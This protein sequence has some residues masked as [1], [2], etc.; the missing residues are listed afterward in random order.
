[1]KEKKSEIGYKD[2]F[3]QKEYLKLVLAGLISRFGDS[4]DSLAFTWL[5]YQVTGS[6]AWSAIVFAVNQLPEIVVQPFAGALVEGLPK[7]RLI[8]GSYLIRGGIVAALA[9]LTYA[10]TVTPWILV[11]FTF[12]IT[13]VEAFGLPAGMAIVPMLLPQEYYEYGTSLKATLSNVVEL[14][15]MALGGVI[16]GAFGIYTAIFIDAATF[17]GAAVILSLVRLKEKNEKRER[18][19]AGSYLENLRSGI[20]YVKEQPVIRNFCLMAVAI[21]ALMVPFNSLQGPIVSELFGQGPEFLSIMGVVMVLFTV[22]GSFLFPYVSKRISVRRMLVGG[23]IAMGVG[24]SLLT[25]GPF[26]QGNVFMLYGIGGL[27]S[28]VMGAGVSIF[29]GALN[30]QFMKCVSKEYLAR[31]GAIFNAAASA[32]V[33]ATSFLISALATRFS[34]GEILMVSALFCVIIFIYIEI[35][36]VQFE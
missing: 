28:L 8:L 9:V 27:S 23:G 19:G 6:A 15:G 16:I 29:M 26:F 14:V 1:M 17:F 34:V 32:A 25:I 10:D 30:V 12:M 3:R 33:P 35:R 5:V 36:K 4:V 2:I 11:I 31:S 20:A 21:N 24:L 18:G 22:L 13:T 7:K